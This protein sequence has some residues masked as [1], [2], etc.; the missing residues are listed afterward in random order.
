M[1]RPGNG[2]HDGESARAG[3]G[4]RVDTLNEEVRALASGT[5]GAVTELVDKIDL[6]GRVRRHPYGMLAAGVGLGYVLGGG[7]FTPLTRRIV[8]L[9]VRLA[10]LPLVKDELV[11]LAEAALDGH[12][13]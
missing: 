1:K 7:F 9:A 5:Q 4:A 12:A 3:F 6:R 2:V 10:A 8:R 11:G 13:P